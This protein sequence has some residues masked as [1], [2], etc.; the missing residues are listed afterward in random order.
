MIAVLFARKDSIYKT[1]TEC[2]VWDEDRNALNF[3]GK[4]PIIAHPPC[5]LWGVLAHLST[6]PEKD[7]EIEK[8]YARFCIKKIRRNGGVLE[9]PYASKLWQDMNLPDVDYVDGFGGYTLDVCQYWWGHRLMK[10]TK[11]YIVGADNYPDIPI[12]GGKPPVVPNS[13]KGR[14]QLAKELGYDPGPR[15]TTKEREATPHAFAEWLC[16]LVISIK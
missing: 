6:V 16:K 8:N 13:G 3:N 5:R 1:M 14:W 2:D 7:R 12:K 15:L 10:R 11:L 9:H 4:E